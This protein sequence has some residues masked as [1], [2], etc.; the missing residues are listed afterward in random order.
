MSLIDRIFRRQAAP[1]P[2]RRSFDAETGG[3]RAHGFRASGP[4]GAETIAAAAPIR[5]RARH[6]Y[7]NNGYLRNAVGAWVAET[8]GAGI[9]AN[10]SHPDTDLRPVI[11][12]HFNARAAEIDAEGRTDFRGMTAAVVEAVIVDGEAFAMIEEGPEGVRLR[13]IPAEM[14]DESITRDLGN[15]GYIAAGVEFDQLG[16]RVAYHVQPHRPTELFPTAGQPVR[17]PAEDMLHIF[18]PLGAGQ[19]RG[20][21]WLAPIL[22][23]VNEFD[24][25][26]DALLVGAKIAAMH[27]GFVTDQNNLNGGGA[28]PDADGLA[29]LSLEP[30][31]VRVLPAGTDIKFNSPTEAKDSIA[32]AKLTLGQIA[33]GLGVP[34]HLLDGD[35]SGAN[36]SSLRAGLLP[37]RAKVEQFQYHALVPQFLA[38]AFRRVIAHEYISGRLDVADLEPALKAEWLAPRP[39]QVDPAKDVAALKEMLGAGLTSRRQA[40]ASLGWNIAD[41]DAEIAAD[42][43]REAALGLNFS[44]PEKEFVE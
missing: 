3:R 16:R 25:L 22:L 39:M 7:A 43:E 30:G 17:V 40:V 27:A 36:Y 37:F 19:V 21:S 13:L 42:R 18:K 24:Q 15:G 23:T 4:V 5:A 8:V 28:F 11:D 20:V 32:F 12:S 35:L 10:S 14:V 31:V 34:Q 38:P 26:Q 9:E 29:D 6:A 33:A 2:I 41:L 44:N 1:A